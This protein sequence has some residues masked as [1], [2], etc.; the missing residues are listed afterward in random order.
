[1][2]GARDSTNLR[3]IGH[4][5]PIVIKYRDNLIKKYGKDSP[6][7]PQRLKKLF[8]DLEVDN[9]EARIGILGRYR[10]EQ[11]FI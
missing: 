10:I 4:L 5:A 6:I 3:Q 2:S 7:V 9:P 11:D 1:M 8:D